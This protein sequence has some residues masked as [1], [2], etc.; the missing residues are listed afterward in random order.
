MKPSTRAAAD[1]G[2]AIVGGLLVFG[3]DHPVGLP[4]LQCVAFVP[5]VV[6]CL[7]APSW[8]WAAVLGGAW[9]VARFA[10]LAVMLGGLGVPPGPAVVLSAYLLLLDAVFA[11]AVF[12][13]RRLAP[14]VLALGAGSVFAALEWADAMLPMW[15]TSK[16]LARSWVVI[17]EVFGGV[18]RLGGPSLWAL[19]LVAAQVAVV[20]G[21]MQQRR[22]HGV[23]V[24]VVL[25]AFAGALGRAGTPAPTG[26]LRVG[27]V[28]WPKRGGEMDAEHWVAVAAGEGARMVVLPEAA[29]RLKEGERASFDERWAAVARRHRIY[30]VVGFVEREG[31]GNAL[32]VFDPEGAPIGQYVKT[33]LI[34]LSEPF[35]PG[36]GT[37]LVFEVDGVSVGTMICQDDNFR[38]LT[39][40]YVQAGVDLVVV[41][42]NEGP[43]E[44]A[45]YHYRNARLRAV[46]FPV[47]LVRAAARGTSAVVAAGG[48]VVA[49]IDHPREGAGAVVADAPY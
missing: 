9:A 49:A 23:V 38:D 18:V 44:V 46:E 6:G 14:S 25:V 22:R 8:R 29:F 45:P 15:G 12:G 20:A 1:V 37:L 41:P 26:H 13:M 21:I 2:L 5:L 47:T 33:H 17:P 39:E 42:T 30:L 32:A 16:S 28:A 10:P 7:R 31:I 35:E 34:P 27:A 4:W 19:L 43:P 11:V 40:A 48:A 36:D 24:A 3:A